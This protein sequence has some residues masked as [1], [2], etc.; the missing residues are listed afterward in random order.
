MS[1]KL[2]VSIL[3]TDPAGSDFNRSVVLMVRDHPIDMRD[4]NATA[5]LRYLVV[6]KDIRMEF[7]AL[8]SFLDDA[9]SRGA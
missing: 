3:S 8:R 4:D 1:A 9:L 2:V 5:V 7:E 6:D